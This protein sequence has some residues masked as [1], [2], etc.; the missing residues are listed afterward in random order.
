MNVTLITCLRI[1]LNEKSVTSR[2]GIKPPQMQTVM[3]N[4]NQNSD[5]FLYNS[6]TGYR[7][8]NQVHAEVHYCGWKQPAGV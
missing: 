2:E 5:C 3:V 1:V 7:R 8:R 6:R 4:G